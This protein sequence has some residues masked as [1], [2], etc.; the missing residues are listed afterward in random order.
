MIST[1]DIILALVQYLHDIIFALLL[2][3]SE[4]S[5]KNKYLISNQFLMLKMRFPNFQ[6]NEYEVKIER[7]VS[8]HVPL[9]ANDVIKV[10]VM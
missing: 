3:C 4:T 6:N 1:S 7:D 2:F 9:G 8:F 10:E 5:D